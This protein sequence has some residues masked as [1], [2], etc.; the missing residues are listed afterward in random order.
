ME[1]LDSPHFFGGGTILLI[2]SLLRSWARIANCL[3]IRDYFAAVTSSFEVE[4]VGHRVC[5]ELKRKSNHGSRN[6]L[7]ET[8]VVAKIYARPQVD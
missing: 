7:A 5:E 2:C 4:Q 8:K 6:K 3:S 1:G